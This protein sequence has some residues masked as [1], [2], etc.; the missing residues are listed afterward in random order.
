[1][2]T[3]FFFFFFNAAHTGILQYNFNEKETPPPGQVA[4]PTLAWSPLVNGVTQAQARASYT[5]T[6]LSVLCVI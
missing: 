2:C 4:V 5:L 6:T 3:F 1:M